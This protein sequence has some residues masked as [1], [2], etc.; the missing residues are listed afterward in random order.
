[1]DL[2]LDFNDLSCH[3]KERLLDFA[4]EDYLNKYGREEIKK[5]TFNSDLDYDDLLF[6]KISDHLSKI[7]IKIK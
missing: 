7:T 3:L 5:E 1:M 2:Y 4:T 6:S